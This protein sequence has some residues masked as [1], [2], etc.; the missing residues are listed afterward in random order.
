MGGEVL[1]KDRYGSGGPAN[2]LGRVGEP[3]WM[4][5]M[6][7]GTIQDV[8]NGTGDTPAGLRRVGGLSWR[9]GTGRGTLRKSETGRVTLKEVRDG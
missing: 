1:R 9:S 4:S 8:R 3:S 5:R 6:G 7:R 2:V